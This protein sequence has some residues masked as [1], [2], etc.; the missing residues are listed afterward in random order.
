MVEVFS[1]GWAVSSNAMIL[2]PGQDPVRTVAV[3]FIV[4]EP[5]TYT[6]TWL[7]LARRL[8]IRNTFLI[9]FTNP[10]TR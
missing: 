3:E 10:L 5:E 7:E 2:A 8:V 9:F 6:V 1:D 4:K